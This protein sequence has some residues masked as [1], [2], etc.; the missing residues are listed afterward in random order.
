MDMPTDMGG[1]FFMAQ[2]DGKNVAG[3]GEM[4]PEMSLTRLS[5]SIPRGSAEPHE[6]SDIQS[7]AF[8][9]GV[10]ANSRP[11]HDAMNGSGIVYNPEFSRFIFTETADVAPGG[12]E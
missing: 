1:V 10:L 3:L 5:L 11:S 2:I 4:I 7:L 8:P 12:Q 9:V 6:Q